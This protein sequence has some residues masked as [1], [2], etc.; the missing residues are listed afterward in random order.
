MVRTK[1]EMMIYVKLLVYNKN[2]KKGAILRLSI[3][4]KDTVLPH[5]PSDTL[6][7]HRTP[8]AGTLG[9]AEQLCASLAAVGRAALPTSPAFH[10]AAPDRTGHCGAQDR[11][12]NGVSTPL[13]RPSKSLYFKPEE[14]N[15]TNLTSQLPS[16]S[17]A[18][19][20]PPF[21]RG[22]N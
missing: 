10:R 12:E 11:E 13:P 2:S 18:Q 5:T 17:G 20:T 22:R 16:S 19:L 15:T 1:Y 14:F 8:D 9:G 7:L 3:C 6:Q 21:C 4:W